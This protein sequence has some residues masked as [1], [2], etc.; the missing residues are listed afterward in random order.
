MGKKKGDQ[1][2]PGQI[3]KT[4]QKMQDEKYETIRE[5]GK[6]WGGFS[7]LVGWTNLQLI[8]CLQISCLQMVLYMKTID[9]D[10]P[11]LRLINL[12]LASY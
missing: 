2:N 6:N 5:V 9:N 1:Y 4:F 8:S 12:D 3:T 11:D 7:L 10:W